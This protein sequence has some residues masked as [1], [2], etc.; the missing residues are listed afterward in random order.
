MEAVEDYLV[1]A[2]QQV[3]KGR[4]SPAHHFNFVEEL[5]LVSTVEQ[6]GRRKIVVLCPAG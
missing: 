2:E 1:L 5:F 6:E 4:M 3:A